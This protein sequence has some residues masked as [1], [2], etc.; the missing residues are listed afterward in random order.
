MSGRLMSG[1][2]AYNIKFSAFIT[3]LYVSLYYLSKFLVGEGVFGGVSSMLFLPAFVRLLAFLVIGYW[4]LPALFVA[5]LFCVELGFGIEGKIIVSAFIA[6]GA[7]MGISLA[8]HVLALK[9]TLSNLTPLRLLWLAAASAFG[10]SLFY[11]WGLGVAGM[12]T[13]APMQYAATFLGDTLG[14]WAM[15]YLIKMGL[16]GLQRLRIG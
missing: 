6:I 8:S 1:E 14:T 10:N 16:A 4:S 11:H 5:G 13:H 2:L 9:P 15:I 7:P 12:D 3:L